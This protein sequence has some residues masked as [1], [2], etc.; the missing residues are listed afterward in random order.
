VSSVAS[1]PPRLEPDGL[2]P[3]VVG[4]RTATGRHEQLVGDEL[5]RTGGH[6]D[7]AVVGAP[8]GGDVDVECGPRRRDRAGPA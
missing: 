4:A 6:H 8:G 7:G 2:Q 1:G 3:E 5:L